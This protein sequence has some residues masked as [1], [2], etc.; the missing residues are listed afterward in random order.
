MSI[1]N[2]EMTGA[3]HEMAG[4]MQRIVCAVGPLEAKSSPF[5]GESEIFEGAMD[6]Q[7]TEP[8]EERSERKER[9]KGGRIYTRDRSVGGIKGL[10]PTRRPQN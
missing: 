10:R 5:S 4:E 3:R 9:R 6:R 8:K 2:G 1:Q 7:K